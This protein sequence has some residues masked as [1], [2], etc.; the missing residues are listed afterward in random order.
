[1]GFLQC[2]PEFCLLLSS[3]KQNQAGPTFNQL[4]VLD[5]VSHTQIMITGLGGE[6]F[7]YSLSLSDLFYLF[8]TLAFRFQT[9][10]FPIF[11][12]APCSGIGSARTDMCKD[13]VV[14]GFFP[15]THGVGIS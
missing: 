4:Q 2:K 11:Y 9:H 10:L 7:D 8:S 6:V 12:R 1:M 3:S 5:G 13:V 15:G 14:L